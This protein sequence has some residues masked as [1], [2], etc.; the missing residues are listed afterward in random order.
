[1]LQSNE[2]HSLKMMYVTSNATKQYIRQKCV[3]LQNR[4]KVKGRT[5]GCVVSRSRFGYYDRVPVRY[6][7]QI[8]YRF[9]FRVGNHC[10]NRFRYQNW[11]KIGLRHVLILINF[12]WPYMAKTHFCQFKHN[13]SC[14]NYLYG[15][16]LL[17]EIV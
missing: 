2:V 15:Y 13:V 9:R 7:N 5:Q 1:M 4:L 17:Y 16:S 10:G 11:V 12:Q 6:L 14:Q 3:R 8:R